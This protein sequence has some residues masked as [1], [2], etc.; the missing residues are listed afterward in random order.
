M[1]RSSIGYKKYVAIGYETYFSIGYETCV[2]IGYVTCALI[3]YE[4]CVA[5]GTFHYS[6]QFSLESRFTIDMRQERHVGLHLVFVIPI[7]QR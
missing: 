3:G 6:V 2:S 1:R 5:I 7:I 4:T